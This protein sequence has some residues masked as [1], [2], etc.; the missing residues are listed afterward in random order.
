M[1]V[2]EEVRKLVEDS[3]NASQKISDMIQAIQ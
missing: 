2:S 3:Q 1:V